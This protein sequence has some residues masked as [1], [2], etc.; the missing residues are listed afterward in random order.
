MVGMRIRLLALGFLASSLLGACSLIPCVERRHESG[1]LL[2]CPE[3]LQRLADM[4][5]QL[6]A[7]AS[8][9][10]SVA[11]QHP[12]DLG[13]PW[14]NPDTKELELRITGPRGEDAAREWIAGNAKRSGA[15]KTLDLPR[16]EVP[17]KLVSADRSFRQ[18]TDIQ[19]GSIPATDL[20]DGDA[21]YQT[22][23]DA[24]RNA[25]VITIDRLSGPL[26]RALASR[27]G[28]DAIVI[29]LEPNRPRIGY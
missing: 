25:T 15:G 17:V 23:P 18:L 27:Y 16:P 1:L 22:G 14:A 13:F 12:D 9:A 29:S 20:P 19:H 28:T 6:K 26:L 24:R 7:A 3:Q 8:V 4:P 5:E 10:W 2:V 21:I 11:E